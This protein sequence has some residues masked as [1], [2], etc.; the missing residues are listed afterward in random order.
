MIF[1]EETVSHDQECF[2]LAR[3]LKEDFESRHKQSLLLS[4]DSPK[5]Y[6]SFGIFS[7]SP[8]QLAEQL[9]FIAAVS[10]LIGRGEGRWGEEEGRGRGKGKRRWRGGGGGEEEGKGD[11]QHWNM[12]KAYKASVLV[13]FGT[14]CSAPNCSRG[15]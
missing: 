15:C 12:G 13:S 2:S 1:I 5:A 11:D 10:W 7:L 9:T 3:K 8:Q 4:T 6:P 14:Y